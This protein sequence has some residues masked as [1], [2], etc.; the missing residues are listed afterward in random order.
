MGRALD[1]DFAPASP[2]CEFEV[3]AIEEPQSTDALVERAALIALCLLDVM[4]K[5]EDLVLAKHG[6]ASDAM[7]P[8]HTPDPGEV[9]FLSASAQGFELNEA[10][11]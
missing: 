9:G 5:G 3:I 6:G 7:M 2:V 1:L 11:E 10:D 8:G 4:K